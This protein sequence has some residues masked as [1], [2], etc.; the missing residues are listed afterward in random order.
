MDVKG[1]VLLYLFNK[2]K[3]RKGTKTFLEPNFSL[4]RVKF[5]KLGSSAPLRPQFFK[6]LRPSNI[7]TKTKTKTALAKTKTSK[8]WS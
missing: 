8:K 1:E 7:K 6:F 4:F 5:K 3:L 2:S